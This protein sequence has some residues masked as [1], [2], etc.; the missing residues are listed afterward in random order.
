MDASRDCVAVH[1]GSMST[2]HVSNPLPASDLVSYDRWLEEIGISS[3]TGWRWRKRGLIPTTN[4][5]GRVYVRRSDV[6]AFERRAQAGD[7]ARTP[8]MPR[9]KAKA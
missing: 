1:P 5:N 3:P 6:A 8:T 7:F 9:R 4:I 2:P